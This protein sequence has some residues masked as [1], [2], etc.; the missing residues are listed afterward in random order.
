MLR[1]ITA[2]LVTGFM[3][4]CAHTPDVTFSYYPAK[5]ITVV[6][7]TQTVGCNKDDTELFW[8]NTPSLT[9]TYSSNFAKR[10]QINIKDLEGESADADMTMAFT[11]DGRLKSI[12]QSATGRG[13][14]IVKSAVSLATA[15]AAVPLVKGVEEAKTVKEGCDLIKKWTDGEPV[16]LIYEAR[17]DSTELENPP[18]FKV[19][20]DSQTFYAALNPLLPE[21][22]ISVGK[23]EDSQS[24]PS[25][26]ASSAGASDNAVLLELQ[27][28][29]SVEVTI[30]AG[31]SIIDKARIVIPS[32]QTYK[33]PIPKAASFGKQTFKVTLSEAGAVTNISYGKTAGTA[34]ALNALGA[35]ANV[36]TA[37]VKAAE[38]KAQADL[39]AQQQRLVRC[40]AKPDQ[41]K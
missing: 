38:L 33:L 9:T 35:I 30:S 40:R 19:A 21:L 36:E 22:T 29:G 1:L 25:Y 15:V 16:T 14:T 17:I 18:S 24:G 8:A 27:K 6:A 7:V 2:I 4:G 34:G 20:P 23:F 11:D 3:A 12:N 32:T 37:A 13:E 41:C 28:V 39:I 10:F 31:D 26:N 5:S